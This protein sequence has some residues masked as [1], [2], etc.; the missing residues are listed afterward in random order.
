MVEVWADEMAEAGFAL[1]D[2]RIVE[3]AVV[4]QEVEGGCYGVPGS[5]RATE[6]SL[7]NQNIPVLGWVNRRWAEQILDLWEG[8]PRP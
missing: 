8:K 2:P 7:M 5:V 4:V 1:P 3:A 6:D